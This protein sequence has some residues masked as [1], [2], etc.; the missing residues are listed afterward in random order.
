MGQDN[1]QINHLWRINWRT[2]VVVGLICCAFNFII[3]G[4]PHP[5]TWVDWTNLAFDDALA[6][7]VCD[8]ALVWNEGIKQRFDRVSLAQS[9]LTAVFAALFTLILIT[10]F[11]NA[12]R[13]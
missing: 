8:F 9:L 6:T 11:L 4:R 3:V 7:A 2:A 10:A 5:L 12:A 1:S 13:R